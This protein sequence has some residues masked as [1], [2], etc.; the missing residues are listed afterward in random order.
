MCSTVAVLIGQV[1]NKI[2]LH[3]K[4]ILGGICNKNWK[5]K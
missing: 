3:S 5:K 1:A 4:K 2:S